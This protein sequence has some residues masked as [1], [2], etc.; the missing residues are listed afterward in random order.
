MA[1]NRAAGQEYLHC[2]MQAGHPGTLHYAMGFTW[3]ID[4]A[5]VEMQQLHEVRCPKCNAVFNPGA[6]GSGARQVR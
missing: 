3:P 5:P 2:E 1:S 6:P 4:G